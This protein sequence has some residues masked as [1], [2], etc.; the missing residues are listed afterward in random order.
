MPNAKRARLLTNVDVNEM[1]SMTINELL[2]VI[3]ENP[4][5]KIGRQAANV[6][7]EKYGRLTACLGMK[8]IPSNSSVYKVAVKI[9]DDYDEPDYRVIPLDASHTNDAEQFIRKIGHKVTSIYIDYTVK[10]R[11][12]HL[13]ITIPLQNS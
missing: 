4:N 6:Y 7:G 9:Q 10:A 2:D 13:K 3:D 11:F 1:E 12:I 8:E 5:N